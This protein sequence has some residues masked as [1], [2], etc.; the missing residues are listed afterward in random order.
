[1][2]ANDVL[3]AMKRI[4]LDCRVRKDPNESLANF[5]QRKIVMLEQ[6]WITLEVV[7]EGQ[8]DEGADRSDPSDR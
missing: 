4:E 8:K 5:L 6:R 2:K 7:L 1:M 3:K